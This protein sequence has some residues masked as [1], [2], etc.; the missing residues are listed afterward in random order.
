[1]FN[2]FIFYDTPF[3]MDKVINAWDGMVLFVGGVDK[4][5]CSSVSV[6]ITATVVEKRIRYLV[7]NRTIEV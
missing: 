7:F 5:A 3:V 1:M 4:C 6:S 2:T